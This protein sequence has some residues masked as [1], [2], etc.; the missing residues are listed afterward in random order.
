MFPEGRDGFLRKISDRFLEES[1][2]GNDMLTMNPNWDVTKHLMDGNTLLV[3]MPEQK[4]TGGT[5]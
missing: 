1:R 2:T 5:C 3:I 4:Q